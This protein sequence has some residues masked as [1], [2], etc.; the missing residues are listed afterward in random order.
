MT[1]KLNTALLVIIVVLLAYGFFLKP[2]RGRFQ[3][4]TND[5]LFLVVLDTETG[6]SCRTVPANNPYIVGN[7]WS[8]AFQRLPD[9]A[10][11]KST[12]FKW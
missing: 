10:E 1:E 11:L 12:W 2:E 4:M 3:P 7:E 6:K 9:C 8:E 5:A